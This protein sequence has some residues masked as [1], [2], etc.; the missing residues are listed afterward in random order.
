[1]HKQIFCVT[2]F[3]MKRNL[4]KKWL[5][6]FFFVYLM[7]ALMGSLALSIDETFYFNTDKSSINSGVY[8]GTTNHAVDWLAEDN[9]I[10]RA[11][12][13]TSSALRGIFMLAGITIA[14]FCINTSS[15]LPVK[16]RQISI[17]K[18]TVLLKLR[19]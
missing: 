17:T 11:N 5:Y 4:C 3:D 14:A 15:F 9:T 10:R 6:L 2:I 19:I 1:L 18:N 7:F 16:N 13:N 8:F 12:R